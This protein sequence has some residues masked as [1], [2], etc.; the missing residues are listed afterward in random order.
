MPKRQTLNRKAGRSRKKRPASDASTKR[1]AW[2]LGAIVTLVVAYLVSSAQRPAATQ[3]FEGNLQ[4]VV[5][6]PEL[7]E[8]LL[9]YT[10]MTISFNPETHQPNWVSWELLGSEAEAT[11]FGRESAFTTDYDVDGCA[12]TDD[13]RHSGFDRGHMA[14]AGDMKWSGDAMRESFIMTNICPQ[15]GDLNRGAWQNQS[16]QRDSGCLRPDI[17]PW[18]GNRAHR[19]NRSGCAPSVLQGSA[20]ALHKSSR[21][22]RLHHAQRICERGH[23]GVCRKRRL[24]RGCHRPR[25]FLGTSRRR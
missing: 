24:G 25:L 7:P 18:R 14:P 23:A 11:D 6:N 13:Y 12:T 10:G 4:A 2:A 8:T 9:D 15:A 20:V 22:D 5:T 3:K 16:R 19:R 17:P 1:L 21:S